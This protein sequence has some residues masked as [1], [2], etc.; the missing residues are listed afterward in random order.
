MP[1]DEL[2]PPA[3]SDGGFGS[4]PPLPETFVLFQNYPN[5]F[6]PSTVIRYRL[7]VAGHVV[8]KVYNTLGEEMATLMNGFQ[9]AGVKSVQWDAYGMPSGVYLYTITAGGSTQTMKML[10]LR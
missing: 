3:P 2:P 10:L 8:L 5:P 7:P 1:T 6:N 9:D 4:S